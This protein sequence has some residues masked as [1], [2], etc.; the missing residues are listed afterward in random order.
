MDRLDSKTK[1]EPPEEEAGR[2]ERCNQEI[3]AP[4]DVDHGNTY[5]LTTPSRARGSSPART[6]VAQGSARLHRRSHSVPGYR[7]LSNGRELP[8]RELSPIIE[9]P[10]TTGNRPTWSHPIQR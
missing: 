8:L 1:S 7:R 9:Q 4:I 6:S 10:V 5:R 2:R 3:L